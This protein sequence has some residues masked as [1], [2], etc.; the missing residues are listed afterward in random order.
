MLNLIENKNLFILI[1]FQLKK[2][3]DFPRN[4]YDNFLENQ[5][6]KSSNPVYNFPQIFQTKKKNLYTKLCKVENVNP[7]IDP[8]KKSK[9]FPKHFLCFSI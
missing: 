3:F 1:D 4:K 6:N 9:S 7:V 2:V 5:K 8:K